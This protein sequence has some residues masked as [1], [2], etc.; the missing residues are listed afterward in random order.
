MVLVSLKKTPTVLIN[1]DDQVNRLKIAS[2]AADSKDI[3][4]TKFSGI[5][6]SV[7]VVGCGMSHTTILQSAVPPLCILEDDIGITAH[8]KDTFCVPDDTDAV[9]LGVSNHGYVRGVDVGIK[10]S[11]LA[12]QYN[13]EFKRIYNMCSTHAIVYLSQRYITA[14]N[15]VIIDQLASGSAFDLGLASIHRHF[16]ILTPNKPFFYQTEQPAFTNLEL[17]V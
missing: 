15:A 6:H 3:V 2:A 5:K 13:T 14:A 16:K 10:G 1:L 7:G 17:E 8:Y 12:S 9:Y 4:F 11:V